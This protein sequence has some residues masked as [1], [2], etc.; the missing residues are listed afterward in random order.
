M[1][2]KIQNIS[3]S[4]DRFSENLKLDLIKLNVIFLFKKYIK[5]NKK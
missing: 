4:Y 3:A 5:I 1:F 2:P